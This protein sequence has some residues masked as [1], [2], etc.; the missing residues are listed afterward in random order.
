MIRYIIDK[1]VDLECETD[2]KSK[3]IHII[4]KYSTPE[5]FQYMSD[6]GLVPEGVFYAPKNG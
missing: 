5:M 1:G 6:K 2:T 4:C 3:P